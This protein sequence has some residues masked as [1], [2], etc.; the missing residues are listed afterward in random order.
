MMMATMLRCGG[1]SVCYTIVHWPLLLHS[2]DVMTIIS[3][4]QQVWEQPQQRGDSAVPSVCA[5]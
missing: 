2:R 1:R 3:A 5:I 4:G